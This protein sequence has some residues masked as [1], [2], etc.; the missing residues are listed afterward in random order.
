MP[1]CP[2]CMN[3]IQ[4]EICGFHMQ[5]EDHKIAAAQGKIINDWLM[6][7]KIPKRL[8]KTDRLLAEETNG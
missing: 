4:G 1:I 3:S 2:I 6:R 5:D 8:E 7:G